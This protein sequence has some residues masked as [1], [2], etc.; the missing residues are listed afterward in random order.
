MALFIGVDTSN[1][2]TSVA[3]FDS[4]SG[5]VVQ[6]KRL[7]RVKEGERGLRQNEAVFQHT[8]ALPE[9]VRE[10]FAELG[11][12]PVAGV[13]ASVKPRDEEGSYMPC[14]LVGSGAASML[15]SALRVPF[16]ETTH[17]AGH[18]LAA[19]YSAGKTDLLQEPFLAFHVSGGTTEALLVSPGEER[20]VRTEIVARTLDLNAGQAVDRVGVA[21]GLGFPAGAQLDRLAAESNKKFSIKPVLKGSDCCLSGLENICQNKIDAGEAKTDIAKYCIDYLSETLGAMTDTLIDGFGSLPL[22]FSGGVT[23][24]SMIRKRFTERF[25][26]F[27]AEPQFSADNAAGVALFAWLKDGEYGL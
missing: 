11:D 25:G 10:L 20:I 12:A 15:A 21:M 24:N 2:T 3:A 18:I 17:Q 1:Y 9:L 4:E 19:L 22:V 6:K 8:L 7:L 5:Q 27:F 13:A 14:F 23:A 26:A 16:Y